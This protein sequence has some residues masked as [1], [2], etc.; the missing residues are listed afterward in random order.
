MDR[1]H[2]DVA[3]RLVV[4]LLDALAQIGLHDLDAPI[5]EERPHVALVGEHRLGLD[6][7]ARIAR[8]HDVEHDL[9]VLGGVLGPMHVRAVARSRCA[10]TPPDSRARWV[11]VCS[12]IADASVRSSSHSGRCSLSRS[13]F[14]RRSHSRLSWKS[15]W[16]LALM[17]FE[18]AF[19]VV[20][21]LHARA[22]FRIC[23]M[24]MNLIGRPRR[25]AHP[26]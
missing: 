14:L 3:R 9:V 16:S 17:N 8:A 26:F 24:W 7:R 25:S 1:G 19:G 4:E 13:R 11:S 22:P 18:D 23:A 6:Q 20:D 12:L 5:L 15:R 2:D 10:R 21:A